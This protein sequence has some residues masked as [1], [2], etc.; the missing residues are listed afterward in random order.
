MC[1][2]LKA[3]DTFPEWLMVFQMYITVLSFFL[4]LFPLYLLLLSLSLPSLPLSNSEIFSC[5][6]LGKDCYALTSTSGKAFVLGARFEGHTWKLV[7]SSLASVDLQP[8][9]WN[10]FHLS[11]PLPWLCY[12]FSAPVG[13]ISSWSSR[14]SSMWKPDFSTTKKPNVRTYFSSLVCS[15][16]SDRWG[17]GGLTLI[18][19]LMS[20]SISLECWARKD[21]EIGSA[22]QEVAPFWIHDICHAGGGRLWEGK[23]PPYI[24]F[25]TRQSVTESLWFD[26]SKTFVSC[27]QILIVSSLPLGNFPVF[28]VSFPNFLQLHLCILFL[29]WG[30]GCLLRVTFIYP[31]KCHRY[32][33]F[34]CS[35]YQMSPS[36]HWGC[37]M[38]C[39]FSFSG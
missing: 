11:T 30:G 23:V 25:Y 32:N 3:L 31:L 10:P 5:H 38:V 21:S 16:S 17:W 15:V 34:L 9:L 2:S 13:L 27:L 37:L 28:P 24:C 20:G 22:L 6:L 35:P 19:V 1:W 29:L 4:S 8:L 33:R 12:L 26:H 7:T 14:T 39:T 18:G 36:W